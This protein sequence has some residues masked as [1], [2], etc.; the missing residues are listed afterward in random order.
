MFDFD[1][2]G[3]SFGTRGTAACVCFRHRIRAKS[4]AS[5]GNL[6]R[7]FDFAGRTDRGG[8]EI[9]DGNV[10]EVVH[11]TSFGT[12]CLHTRVS[13]VCTQCTLPTVTAHGARSIWA[14]AALVLVSDAAPHT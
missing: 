8:G 9:Q 5:T 2:K 14:C 6:G 1:S 7:V 12:C 13:C 10:D 4:N 3:A 11:A